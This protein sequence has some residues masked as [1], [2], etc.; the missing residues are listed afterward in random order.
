MDHRHDLSQRLHDVP[1]QGSRQDAPQGLGLIFA[2]QREGPQPVLVQELVEDRR[3]ESHRGGNR[4]PDTGKAVGQPHL[5]EEPRR[6]RK[7]AALAAQGPSTDLDDAL[8]AVEELRAEGVHRAAHP[9]PAVAVDL[10]YEGVPQSLDGGEVLELPRAQPARQAELGARPQPPGEVV[11]HCVVR[12]GLRRDRVELLHQVL[13]VRSPVELPPL[14]VAE[15]EVPEEEVLR[16]VPSEL[17][18]E[19][20]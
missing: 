14:L 11:S 15:D 2:L 20:R 18:E 9:L 4:D 8:L 10:A 19:V 7:A 6:E 3:A 5:V 16:Q 13:Q 17:M 1:R 12:H